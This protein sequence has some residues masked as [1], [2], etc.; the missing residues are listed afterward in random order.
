MLSLEKLRHHDFSPLIGSAATIQMLIEQLSRQ[1]KIL[2]QPERVSTNFLLVDTFTNELVKPQAESP[3]DLETQRRRQ[4][5]N[6]LA[7]QLEAALREHLRTP[8]HSDTNEIDW[9][10]FAAG[11][12]HVFHRHYVNKDLREH[13]QEAVEA[14][15]GARRERYAREKAQLDRLYQEK[16]TPELED[17]ASLAPSTAALLTWEVR[18]AYNLSP[19]EE[20]FVGGKH[21]LVMPA[22]QPVYPDGWSYVNLHQLVYLPKQR[23]LLVT[24]DQFFAYLSYEQHRSVLNRWQPE[25]IPAKQPLTEKLLMETVITLPETVKASPAFNLFIDLAKQLDAD[26]MGVRQ[27]QQYSHGFVEKSGGTLA[28]ASAF[29]TQILLTE[30]QVCL[31]HPTALAGLAARLNVAFEMAAHPLLSGRDFSYRASLESY[32]EQFLA[33]WL[34]DPTVSSDPNRLLDKLKQPAFIRKS[35][36]GKM[37]GEVAA[38][39]EA[40]IL[41]LSQSYPAILNSFFSQAQCAVGSLGGL[42]KMQTTL[43]S[44]LAR[45]VLGGRQVSF[46]ELQQLV[47]QRAEHFH[48]GRCV[49]PDC[50]QMYG[51]QQQFGGRIP[52][53]QLPYVGECNLCIRCELEHQQRELLAGSTAGKPDNNALG[54]YSRRTFANSGQAVE[55]YLQEFGIQPALLPTFFLAE[56]WVVN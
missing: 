55:S 26:E 34:N 19:D 45:G 27:K 52:E 37:D 15:S 4:L 5:E 25:S 13:C 54:D 22:N 43:N 48:R 33:R 23:K 44:S 56:T 36:S 20:I 10:K 1:T 29:L 7:A 24:I 51:L 50:A 12:L 14:N 32:T 21:A 53:N 9:D 41:K 31:Q 35:R 47:G 17:F 6:T 8:Y 2:P 38:Q 49:N 40:A 42:A 46:S 3:I 30:Y 39:R 16:I 28:L 18:Q 11:E